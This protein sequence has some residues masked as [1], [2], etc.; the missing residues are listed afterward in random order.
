M[1]IPDD[2]ITILLCEDIEERD[3]IQRQL[4]TW[5]GARPQLRIVAQARTFDQ[6][7]EYAFELP[8]FPDLILVDDR[9]GRGLD[10]TPQPSAL[11]LTSSIYARRRRDDLAARCVL[12]TSSDDRQLFWTFR[13]CGGR[14]VMSKSETPWQRRVQLLYDVLDGA[15]WWPPR[16][17]LRLQAKQREAIRY[18]A[19][20][21][22]RADVAAALAIDPP[23]VTR[24]VEELRR[25]IVEQ[26]GGH[27][28][29]GEVALAG[30]ARE[31]GWLW[32]RPRD[33]WLL[34][35]GAPLPLVL[36]PEMLPPAS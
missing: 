4:D 12:W 27:V 2:E 29:T 7:R 26:L 18:F 3:E 35:A 20:G 31:R 34:P 19:E 32:V 28:P 23:L 14:H 13:V 11:E 16:P 6:A 21:M 15:E 36:D 1:P 8:R 22:S 33:E 24:R 9:L 10:A 25:T 30:V 17:T 5:R